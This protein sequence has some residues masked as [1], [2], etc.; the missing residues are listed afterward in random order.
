MT[1]EERI[2]A[3]FGGPKRPIQTTL[4]E[5]QKAIVGSRLGKGESLVVEAGAGSGKTTCMIELARAQPPST[6]LLYICFNNKG[7]AEAREKYRRAGITNT[8]AC[9]V[10]ALAEKTKALY[11]KAGKFQTKITVK[12]IQKHHACTRRRAWEVLETIRRFCESNDRIPNEAHMPQLRDMKTEET[13]EILKDARKMWGKMIDLEQPAPLSYDQY[14]KVF[15][16]TDPVL[17]YDFILLDEAQDSNPLTLNLLEKQRHRSRLVLIGDTNQTIY[18][19]RGAKDAIESWRPEHSFS[20]T[21]SF[22][23]GKQIAAVANVILKTFGKGGKEITGHKTE[24]SV[25]PIP[26]HLKHTLIART[27]ATLFEEALSQIEKGRKYHF[28]GTRA[29]A[30]WD[31]TTPYRFD[32]AKDVYRLYIGDRAGVRNPHLQAFD[33]YAELKEAAEG[34]KTRGETKQGDKELESLC[35]I[36]EKHKR[37]LPALIDRIV[38]NCAGPGEADILLTTCHRAKGLEWPRV[39]MADDFTKLVIRKPEERNIPRLT[40]VGTGREDETHP[41]EI[42]LIYVAATRAMER[43]EPNTRTLELLRCPEL[44]APGASAPEIQSEA[45]YKPSEAENKEDPG[46]TRNEKVPFL[47]PTPFP[48]APKNTGVPVE[49]RYENKEAAKKLATEKGG[50]LRWHATK[51]KWMWMHKDGKP[52]PPEL[53]SLGRSLPGWGRH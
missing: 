17:D 26:K 52:P 19:W 43:L 48:D 4:T 20:L 13:E 18:S 27:N 51:R 49:I 11:E 40:K 37:D 34:V 45:S 8:H 14:L 3:L 42:N 38:A 25:G 1:T 35:R 2:A 24:D 15:E 29:D 9:T 33:T 23:F 39:R 44:I 41:E 31:P 46:L 36:V 53:K 22:R 28:V 16:L 6:K 47:G 5:E 30:G 12:D 50:A 10:H 21:E 7:A 32:D